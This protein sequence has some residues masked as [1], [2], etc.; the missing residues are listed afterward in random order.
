[1][2]REALGFFWAVGVHAGRAMTFRADGAK[3]HYLDAEL[4][5]N[6]EGVAVR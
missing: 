3:F 6:A 5:I 2:L 4:A 1:M